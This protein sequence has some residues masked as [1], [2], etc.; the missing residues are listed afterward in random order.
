MALNFELP[1]HKTATELLQAAIEGARNM[2]RDVKQL[3]GRKVVD[4]VTEIVV[5]IYRANV[6]RDKVAHIIVILERLQVVE[7][8]LRAA[9]DGHYIDHGVYARAIEQS[10]SLGRQATGWKKDNATSPAS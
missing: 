5:M 3:V 4:E 2:P 7:L 1:I 9:H 10:Q 8:L 6:A